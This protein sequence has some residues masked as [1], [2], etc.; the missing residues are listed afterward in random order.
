MNLINTDIKP[1]PFDPQ[2][3]DVYEFGAPF[4][5]RLVIEDAPSNE[6]PRVRYRIDGGTDSNLTS[7]AQ[8]H[9]HLAGLTDLRGI[10]R[11]REC[12]PLKPDEVVRL[13]QVLKAT[14]LGV[15]KV[16]GDLMREAAYA[17]AEMSAMLRTIH[18]TVRVGYLCDMPPAP[19]SPIVEIIRCAEET[20]A[21]TIK[22][23]LIAF[24]HWPANSRGLDRDWGEVVDELLAGGDA[25]TLETATA[26][27]PIPMLLACPVCHTRHVDEGEWSTRPHRTHLCGRCGATWRPALVHTVGVVALPE[28]QDV[29]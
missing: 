29:T 25:S 28:V 6:D 14:A 7:V 8:F 4:V 2:T 24:L 27:S 20:P 3:G 18:D 1:D 17:I 11:V 13:M 16:T 23:R 10:G 26:P 19:P 12:S 15:D 21:E 5:Q 22:Q 9:R